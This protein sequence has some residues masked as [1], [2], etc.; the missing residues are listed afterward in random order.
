MSGAFLL[1]VLVLAKAGF[2]PIVFFDQI[3]NSP[4]IQD[5]VSKMVLR[6]GV[7]LNGVEAGQ[8]FLEPALFMKAPLDQIS[9]GMALVFGTAGMPH[10][11]M[12]FF[13]VP[14]AQAAR[15]SVI[16]AMF[17]I[18]GFYVLTTLLGFGAAI[19][20]TPQGIMQVDKGGNMATMMLAQQLGADIAPIFGDLLLAFLCAVAL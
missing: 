20:V 8:R 17:I 19:Y 9:L 2:N 15:K 4:D 13:T 14:T 1:S 10:I 7:V 3:V 5:H 6:D 11:L 18:G 16:I 12:R